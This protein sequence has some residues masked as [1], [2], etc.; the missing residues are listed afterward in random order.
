MIDCNSDFRAQE[1]LFY[2]EFSPGNG[3]EV[4]MQRVPKLAFHPNNHEF[5][6]TRAIEKMG[7]CSISG[8]YRRHRMDRN[9]VLNGAV[10]APQTLKRV[11][12]VSQHEKR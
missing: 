3:S 4:I 6:S 10:A 1:S 9:P 12:R 8:V 2:D 11:P 5:D 7:P